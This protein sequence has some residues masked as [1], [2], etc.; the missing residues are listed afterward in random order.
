MFSPDGLWW[1]RVQRNY[2]LVGG[3][4]HYGLR[5]GSSFLWTD[6]GAGYS[7][8]SIGELLLRVPPTNIHQMDI[9]GSI[10]SET[11][12]LSV[13]VLSV[14]RRAVVRPWIWTVPPVTGT[15]ILGP[16]SFL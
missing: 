8:W 3:D 4:T 9:G 12:P 14:G 10:Q 1:N 6:S 15:G 11:M 13:V 7:H 2:A 5:C 16:P